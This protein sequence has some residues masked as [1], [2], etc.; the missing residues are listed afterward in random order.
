MA[1]EREKES[2]L[3]ERHPNLF[4]DPVA[5]QAEGA[6]VGIAWRLTHR[7]FI[8]AGMNRS[9]SPRLRWRRGGDDGS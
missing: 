7:C 5:I 1:G 9:R 8:A 6:R 3:R 4:T 2:V